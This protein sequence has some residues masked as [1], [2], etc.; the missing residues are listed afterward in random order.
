MRSRT[1]LAGV[2]ALATVLAGGT[3]RADIVFTLG[4]NPQPDEQNIQ[5]EAADEIPSTHLTGDTN[6]TGVFVNFDSVFTAGPGSL[7]GNGTGQLMVSSGIGQGDI[8]CSAGCVDNSPP[9]T[10]TAQL[11]SLQITPTQG[12]GFHD[13]IL[14]PTHGH[15]QMN[16]YVKDN[17]GNN[18]DFDLRQGQ[19]FLTITT[20]NNEAITEIQLT[21]LTG[22]A[23]PF[24]WSDLAQPRV[25]GL[26]TIGTSTC[27][28]LST[29]EPTS[30]ALLG[31]GV[32]GL[33]L[34][35]RRKRQ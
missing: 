27:E 18:F 6:Q 13:F 22:S 20:A 29:P 11:T 23:T 17:L 10:D 28:P 3:A 14:N 4:N 33:G 16:V 26:C 1:I 9:G 2:A 30:L 5:F 31:A 35:A 12:F 21:Q 25:S 34:L 19:D 7:G 32:L 24:G 8:V 15:G